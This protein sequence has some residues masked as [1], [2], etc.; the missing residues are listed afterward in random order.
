MPI[1]DKCIAASSPQARR[2]LA[3]SRSTIECSHTES[4]I[5]LIGKTEI[6]YFFVRSDVHC[7]DDDPCIVHSLNKAFVCLELH[8]LGGEII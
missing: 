1:F 4:G 2:K 8:V 6:A 7:P 3:V 5:F